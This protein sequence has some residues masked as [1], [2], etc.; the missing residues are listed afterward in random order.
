MA[1]TASE[2][3]EIRK[4]Q[5]QRLENALNSWDDSKKA[6]ERAIAEVEAQ[7]KQYNAIASDVERNMAALEMVVAMKAEMHC[8]PGPEKALLEAPERNIVPA[9]VT[10]SRPLFGVSVRP[11]RVAKPQ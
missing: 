9:F 7:E 5:Q 8:E 11:M 3:E 1:G 4:W 6:L 10:R 2:I